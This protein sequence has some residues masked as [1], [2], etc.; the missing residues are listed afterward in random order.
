MKERVIPFLFSV[1]NEKTPAPTLPIKK[2]GKGKVMPG[3]IPTC[4]A[5]VLP[6]VKP[7]DQENATGG[8]CSNLVRSANVCGN[9]EPVPTQ[10]RD[11][12]SVEEPIEVKQVKQ[13]QNME[14]CSEGKP[15]Q[16]TLSA[17]APF[18]QAMTVRFCTDSEADANHNHVTSSLEEQANAEPNVSG[19]KRAKNKNGCL[20]D[21]SKKNSSL[22]DVHLSQF[23]SANVSR[24]SHAIS[25]HS[26]GTSSA[27]EQIG[28]K[29]E[30]SRAKGAKNK[31]LRRKKFRETASSR[32]AR[33]G[34]FKSADV[35]GVS[36]VSVF[37][38]SGKSSVEEQGV[39]EPLVARTKRTRNEEECKQPRSWDAQACINS[40]E[41][42]SNVTLGRNTRHD[43]RKAE[44]ISDAVSISK[45]TEFTSR[46]MHRVDVQ[47]TAEQQELME[48][49][50]SPPERAFTLPEPMET[51]GEENAKIF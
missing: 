9:S 31:E 44:S 19:A 42:S 37:Q 4:H 28:V 22:G 3:L 5:A 10:N 38:T 6:R 36:Q 20:K 24:D 41:H 26:V 27:E 11:T 14:E 15:R 18:L 30:V 25:T 17:D 7:Q 8:V 47:K 46:Q 23:C 45:Q 16:N 2:K 49:V 50:D 51:G 43:K 40:T 12:S 29:P 39:E 35:C 34:H 1:A 48:V 33:S 21:T 13:A 32:D